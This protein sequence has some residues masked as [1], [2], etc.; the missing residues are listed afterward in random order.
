MRIPPVSDA[1]IAKSDPSKDEED[2][3]R[4]FTDWDEATF[5][6]KTTRVS[7]RTS[8]IDE[9]INPLILVNFLG[10]GISVALE[11]QQPIRLCSAGRG[12][13]RKHRTTDSLQTD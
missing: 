4:R 7:L 2:Y 8:D 12:A 9:L 6:F 5:S 13:P 10:R 11:L 3:K 1:M